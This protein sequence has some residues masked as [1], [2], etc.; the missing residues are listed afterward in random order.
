[1][2]I[3]VS[4]ASGHLVLNQSLF[5]VFP[6]SCALVPFFLFSSFSFT[7]NSFG[8]YLK[9]KVLKPKESGLIAKRR[10][11]KMLGGIQQSTNNTN[12]HTHQF[13]PF[14]DYGFLK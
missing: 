10:K 4:Y 7:A 12:V 6:S 5:T 11:N 3:L 1:M 14:Y 9:E 13:N 8:F 2:T